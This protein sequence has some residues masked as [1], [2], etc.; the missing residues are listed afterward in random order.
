MTTTGDKR[1]SPLLDRLGDEVKGSYEK[2]RKLLDSATSLRAAFEKLETPV[3]AAPCRRS[4][5]A[6]TVNV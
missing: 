6:S 3:R 1:S 4:A 2:S 5:T